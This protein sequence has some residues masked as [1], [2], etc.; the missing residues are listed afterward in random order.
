M[1]LTYLNYDTPKYNIKMKKPKTAEKYL[2]KILKE[3]VIEEKIQILEK[4]CQL[5]Q[6]ESLFV[7]FTEFKKPLMIGILLVFFMQY[8]GVN[9]ITFYSNQIF[10]DS[11]ADM[12]N[13]TYFTIFINVM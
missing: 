2:K 7:M 13:L 3:E 8:S 10:E 6:Q 5:Q 11:G 1:L 4:D 12:A 9:A